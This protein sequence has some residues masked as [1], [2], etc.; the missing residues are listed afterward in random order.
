[1]KNLKA[2]KSLTLPISEGAAFQGEGTASAKSLSQEDAWLFVE[3]QRGG[4]WLAR[5]E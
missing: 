2:Q 5:R 4:A 3:E 1:M